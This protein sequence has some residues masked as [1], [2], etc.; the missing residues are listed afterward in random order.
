VPIRP[1][2]CAGPPAPDIGFGSQARHASSWG[3]IVLTVILNPRELFYKTRSKSIY[4]LCRRPRH[5]ETASPN[6]QVGHTP[7][8][9][10]RTGLV[11]WRLSGFGNRA[12]TV[13]FRRRNAGPLR[14][15]GV[16]GSGV[17]SRCRSQA[18][19][20]AADPGAPCRSVPKCAPLD[21]T[22]SIAYHC[23]RP[24]RNCDREE[25]NALDR[26]R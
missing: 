8:T 26:E 11:P 18:S 12:S 15:D 23:F 19:H 14:I 10:W 5:S 9:T 20:V 25:R 3:M 7:R 16:R 4:R 21:R 1:I 2:V 24:S 13:P 6:L 22:G 17:Q